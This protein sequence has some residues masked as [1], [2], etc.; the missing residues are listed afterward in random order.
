[1]IW[2]LLKTRRW[3]GFT[4]VVVGAIVAFGLL[5]HWQWTR[6]DD[7]REQRTELEAALA[8]APVPLSQILAAPDGG[9]AAADQWRAV[10]LTGR[11]LSES[12][13]LARKRPLDARNGFWVLT[14]MQGT[15][16]TVAWIN[17][18]WLPAGPDALSTPD[19]PLLLR[20][21]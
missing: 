15:D 6:A 12:Q 20:E 9:I 21:T 8:S 7:K 17:R 18:G 16:G 4:A 3:L 11:Y 5:S 10:S 1:M 14:A 2:P 19:S 13:V